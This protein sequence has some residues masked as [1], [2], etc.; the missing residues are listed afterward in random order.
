MF[1]IKTYN[2]IARRCY[3]NVV[4]TVIAV[5]PLSGHDFYHFF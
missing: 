3:G 5:E 4:M 1:G 2:V